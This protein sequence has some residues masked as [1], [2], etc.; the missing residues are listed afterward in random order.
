MLADR[1]QQYGHIRAGKPGDWI[2]KRCGNINFSQRKLCHMNSCRAPPIGCER[3]GLKPGDWTCPS[4]GDLCFSFRNTCNLCN[5]AK[6]KDLVTTGEIAGQPPG[7]KPLPP[8]ALPPPPPEEDAKPKPKFLFNWND[9]DDDKD[10][11]MQWPLDDGQSGGMKKTHW[12]CSG[13]GDRQPII[14]QSCRMCGE[15]QMQSAKAAAEGRKPQPGA[16]PKASFCDWRS[17]R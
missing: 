10:Q 8:P 16:A 14:N 5:T 11:P 9:P 6:P 4:C 13:C 17:R 15:S 7:E 12:T 3:I 1:N 2:C